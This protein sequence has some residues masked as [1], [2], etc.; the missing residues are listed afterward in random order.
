[1][2]WNADN[3]LTGSYFDASKLPVTQARTNQ[4]PLSLALVNFPN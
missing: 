2:I 3:Y 1:L 4:L